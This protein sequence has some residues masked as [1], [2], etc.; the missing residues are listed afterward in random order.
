MPSFDRNPFA[1]MMGNASSLTLEEYEKYATASTVQDFYYT[2][3]AYFNGSDDLLPV[4]DETEEEETTETQDNPFGFEGGMMKGMFSSGD[5]TL[6]GY[7][8][9]YLV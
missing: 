2:L 7:S 1:D 8:S 3:T 4:S 6:V 5:F 9:T